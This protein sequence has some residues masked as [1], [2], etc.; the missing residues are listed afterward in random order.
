MESRDNATKEGQNNGGIARN[1]TDGG[2]RGLQ[3]DMG[4]LR[5]LELLWY[6]MGTNKS[7]GKGT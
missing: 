4:E 1:V 6:E 3:T 7:F 2:R 5:N